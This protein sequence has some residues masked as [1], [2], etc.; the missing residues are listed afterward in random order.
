MK[1]FFEISIKMSLENNVRANHMKFLF[2][3]VGDVVYIGSL[4]WLNLIHFQVMTI[5]SSGMM[6]SVR[7]VFPSRFNFFQSLL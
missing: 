4:V 6:E 2:L 7:L 5:L 3:Q 1:T